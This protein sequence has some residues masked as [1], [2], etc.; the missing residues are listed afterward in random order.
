MVFTRKGFTQVVGN[1][2]AGMGFPAEGPSVYEFPME[3][4]LPASDLSP[5]KENMDKIIYGLTKWQ[6]KIT[7]KG[8]IRSEM[9]TVEGPDY[10][11]AVDN[12]NLLF[13][14]NLWGDGLPIIPAT[15]ERVNWIL[16]GTDLP[17]DK[18]LGPVLPRG[19]IATVETI[20]ANLAMAGGRPEYLPILIAAVEGILDPAST[21]FHWSPT[22]NSAY[23]AVIVNGPVAKQLR[24]NSGYGCMGPDPQHPAGA[25]IGRAIRFVL[26][27][28]GG[29]IPGIG[30][31]AI[32]GGASRYT[33]IVF[34]EDEDGIPKGWEPL[35]ASYWG[36]P[37]GSNTLTVFP[38]TGQ[39]NIS[40]GT[41]TTTEESVLQT[42]N[43]YAGFMRSPYN[44]YW[45]RQTMFEG[46]PGIMVMARGTAAGFAD[47]GWSKDKIK[48]FL[49]E[50]SKI[51]WADTLKFRGLKDARARMKTLEGRI[52]EG[53]PWP[54]TSKP[55]NIMIAVTGGAQ[56]GHG[57]WM[58]LA[59]TAPT[60]A[61]IVLP[62]NWSALLKQ[63]EQ[64]L[65]PIPAD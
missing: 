65:G 19:G 33:N 31:M 23:P 2:F 43:R 10:Q 47:L 1:A 7:K 54:I 39:V 52:V 5:I 63:A 17:R 20:A 41:T 4:F 34:A 42:L 25:S 36:Y 14:K 46:S 37:R 49:W 3:M 22:T 60:H 11:G 35:N 50:N 21:H 51:S 8:I 29:A 15:E 28:I 6:P 24:I 32:Y 58:Q 56:S 44:N 38:V 59:Q 48:Q 16:T 18:V 40:G 12:M 45:Q 53:Q 26:M 27:D 9:I 13:L 62:K 57:Y 61:K 64:D 30:T 55:K